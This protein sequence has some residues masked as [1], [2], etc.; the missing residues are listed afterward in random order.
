MIKR[1]WVPLLLVLVLVFSLA[2]GCAPTEE[3]TE[4]EP[5][6]EPGEEKVSEEGDDEF[7]IYGVF[8]TPSEEP[9][10]AV[11][12]AACEK[13]QEEGKATFEFID[14]LGYAG[15]FERVL[16]EIAE[17]EKP[18]LITGD[19]FGNEEAARRVAR[20]F[21]DIPFAFGSGLGPV[22]PNFS[23][24]DNWIHEPAYLL[25]MLAGGLTETNKVGVVGGFPVPEVNRINNAFIQGAKEYNPDV[26]VYVNFINS[27][28]DPDAAKEAA[29]AQIEKGADVLYAERFGVIEAAAENGIWVFGQMTDQHELAPDYVVSSSVWNLTPTFEYLL[30]V[31]KA[32]VY[33]A[34]DLKDFSMMGKGGAYLAPYYDL[35]DKLPA[36]L[37]A[38]VEQRKQEILEGVFRVEVDESTPGAVN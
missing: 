35:E 29:L 26:V 7:K 5:V 17:E 25:G 10:D 21:P 18:D 34:Q 38:D 4:G 24:F 1:F 11:I 37:L 22:E 6:A 28:F 2:S 8:S 36:D 19:A 9:W 33:S 32:G 16:R 12:I 30:E 31:I 13:L 3:K 23:V 14:N 15:D 20:D 27:W